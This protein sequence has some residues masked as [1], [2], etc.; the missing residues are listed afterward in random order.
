MKKWILMLVCVLGVQMTAL[1]DNDKPIQIGQLPTKAQT[2]ITTYF[3]NH[4]VALA[5]MESGLF[6]KSYDV[7]FTNGEKLEFDKS[8]DWTE[9]QCKMSEVPVQAVPAEIRSYVSS[10]YPDTKIIQIER[11]GKEYDVKLSNRWE[12]T[13]NNKFQVIDIDGKQSKNGY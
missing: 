12:I 10:T 9:I 13:F 1:A 2:F 3:K 8:G 7:I 11:D 4:K 5:K 6:Y